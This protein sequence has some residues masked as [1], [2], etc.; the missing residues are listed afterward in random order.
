MHCINTAA[1]T[2]V[3]KAE[4]EPEKAFAINAE[5]AKNLA[6]VCAENGTILIHVSTDY[7][8]DGSKTSTYLKQTN[9]TLSM[10]MVLQN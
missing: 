9:P 6:E 2:N 4:S 5:G 8:F 3:E 10:F 7:V 1:Y